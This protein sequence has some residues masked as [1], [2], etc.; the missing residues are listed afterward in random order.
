ML[1]AVLE[2]NYPSYRFKTAAAHRALQSLTPEQRRIWEKTEK[3]TYQRFEG[4]AR[5]DFESRVRSAA[6]IAAALKKRM[7]DAWG[8]PSELSRTQ[9][10]LIAELRAIDKNDLAKRR[11]V[12]KDLESLPSKLRALEWA[13]EL[14]AMKPETTNP[15]QFGRMADILPSLARRLGPLFAPVIDELVWTIRVDHLAYSE[16][17]TEDGPN[18]D[19][20]QKLVA[21]TC[22]TGP[23]D[24]AFLAY[25][26]D[27]NKRMIYTRNSVGEVRRA[28][29]RL[30]ER[31][32]PEH[33]G[34]PMLVLECP[35][36]RAV[37]T[38]EDR[39][40]LIEHAVRRAMAMGIA[41]AF[42]TEYYWDASKTRRFKGQDMNDMN[43]VI[44]ALGREHGAAPIRT[45]IHV[46]NPAGN[47][48]Q[49]YID[50]A[51]L[52]GAQGA[53]MAGVRRYHGNRDTQYENHFVILSPNPA[54]AT[55]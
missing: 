29:L 45:T 26:I 18:L 54:G 24:S 46:L 55:G 49:E 20:M 27:P 40:R 15:P 3:A 4:D 10:A 37:A 6:V 36:P 47:T 22:I 53:G 19:L 35:Y 32:D 8:D 13:E 21:G 41:V 9:A 50:S 5:A 12:A 23:E 25:A 2:N 51:P 34:Q 52:K 30:V 39:Q 38:Q 11:R 33:V 42:P 16:V 43:A 14:S 48:P 1:I 7:V 31:Q 28:V 17:V 44:E